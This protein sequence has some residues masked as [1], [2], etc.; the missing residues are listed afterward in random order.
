MVY[1]GIGL[2][3]YWAGK[4]AWPWRRTP[5]SS[6]HFHC[7]RFREKTPP[8][9]QGQRPEPENR[10][11]RK[12]LGEASCN[13]PIALEVSLLAL[14]FFLL[15]YKTRGRLV[16]YRKERRETTI[17]TP[18]RDN[19]WEHFGPFSFY[20]SITMYTYTFYGPFYVCVFYL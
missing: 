13:E 10:G 7:F 11:V 12:I 20:V 6:K 4:G 2:F 19:H 17:I 8:R 15:D 1:F 3:M 18:P 5:S 16:K 9:P 14:Y